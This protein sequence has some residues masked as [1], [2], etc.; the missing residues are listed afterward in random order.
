MT[1]TILI[2]DDV[3]QNLRLLQAVLEPRG[4]TVVTAT[5]GEEATWPTL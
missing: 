1:A 5:S 4:Y 3:P 2:V